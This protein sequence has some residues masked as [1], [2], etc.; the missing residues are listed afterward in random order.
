MCLLK[1]FEQFMYCETDD[2]V[3]VSKVVSTIPIPT[4]CLFDTLGCKCSYTFETDRDEGVYSGCKLYN[5]A[6]VGE[7]ITKL[8]RIVISSSEV[9]EHMSGSEVRLVCI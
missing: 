4:E 3:V 9:I 2:G 1:G 5:G 7:F 8:P 6:K